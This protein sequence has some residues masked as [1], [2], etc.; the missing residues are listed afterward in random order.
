MSGSR[1]FRSLR[2]TSRTTF[3]VPTPP[4]LSI[5]A[6]STQNNLITSSISRQ[7]TSAAHS[8]LPKATP[9]SIPSPHIPLPDDAKILTLPDGRH[10]GYCEYGSLT[11]TPIIFVHGTPDCRLD[12]TSTPKDLALMQRLNIRLI[13]ID[14][15]GIGLSSSNP[16]RTVSDWIPDVQ[17]LIQ[18]LNLEKSGF[19]ILSIS[20]G[21]AHALACAKLLPREQVRGVG[22]LAGVG[23]LSAGLGGMGWANRIGLGMWRYFPAMVE[24]VHNRSVVPVLQDPDPRKAE[25]M[26]RKQL[27][28][29]PE[30]DRLGLG[31]E[32]SVQA[33]VTIMREV[34]RGGD[35][36]GIREEMRLVTGDWG[37]GVEEVEYKGVKFWYGDE[38]VNTPVQ[39]G[40]WMSGRMEGSILRVFP[41]KSH[42]SIWDHAE[43][44]LTEFLQ[45]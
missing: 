10:M 23:P 22:I 4:P 12:L 26:F 11:G 29:F 41:G 32:E 34:Y 13:G 14:R 15:P 2:Y 30:K 20:G 45:E 40:R 9:P 17:H 42:F 36:S 27:K 39:H 28:Y 33:I 25:N 7:F 44:I 1:L 3:S 19:R 5:I 31:T 43:E 8:Q 6:Q 37:F 35:A 16:G 18:S 24:W 21:T 38:D